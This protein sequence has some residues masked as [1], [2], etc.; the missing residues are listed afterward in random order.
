MELLNIVDNSE[1]NTT[2]YVDNV[3]DDSSNQICS[4]RTTTPISA[5]NQDIGY[6]KRVDGDKL[7]DFK[8]LNDLFGSPML[9]YLESTHDQDMINSKKD[10][11]NNPAFFDSDQNQPNDEDIFS[12]CDTQK[13]S[14]FS[15]RGCDVM[16]K[17]K[18]TLSR[19]K[20]NPF[21]C[22]SKQ[23][24][25]L[26]N[27]RKRTKTATVMRS[28]SAATIL[29]LQQLQSERQKTVKRENNNEYSDNCFI[30][31][32]AGSSEESISTRLAA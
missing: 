28:Q 7:D 8:V 30:N 6:G 9:P 31:M 20:S 25:D 19:R 24:V 16:M 14:N 17:S 32:D 15:E 10:S 29:T 13:M 22:P 12:S 11:I 1:G 21:Y 2:N 5:F 18:P 27:K 4:L 3:D 26:V 23:I